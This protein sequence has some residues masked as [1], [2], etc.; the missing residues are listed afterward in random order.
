MPNFIAY[1]A[2]FIANNYSNYAQLTVV[3]PSQR[4]IK[5]IQQELFRVHKHPVFSPNFITIDAFAKN[6]VDEEL[7]DSVDLLFRFY[8]VYIKQGNDADFET[9]LNWAPM[10]IADCNEID[11]YLVDALQ[12]FKNLRDVKELENWSFD[13]GR[14]LSESQRKFLEFWDQLKDYYSAINVDLSKDGLAYSGSVFRKA[15]ENLDERLDMVYGEQ[16]FL[17]AGFNALSEAELQLMERLVKR[18]RA[19]ILAEADSF[20][21]HNLNHEAGLFIR[22]TKARIPDLK[23]YLSNSLEQDVKQIQ[24]V[25]CAQAGSML[26]VTQDLLSQMSQT[27]IND[28]VLLLADESLIVPA[29]KHLPKTV[30]K[31]NITLG[32][33]LKLTAIRPWLEL[34]FEFQNNFSYFN[35]EALYHKTLMAFFR[36]PF[37][38]RLLSPD[39]KQIVLREEQNI[40]RFNKIFTKLTLEPFSE[41]VQALLKLVFLPWGNDFAKALE[42]ILTINKRVFDAL[43]VDNDL[44]ERSALFHFQESMKGLQVVFEKEYVP[45][46]TLRSFEKFFNMRWMRESVA[47][48]G[49]P[50][51]GL[52]VMGLLETRLLC[53]KNLIVVGLNEGVMPPKNV[54]NSLIPMDLRRFFNLPLPAEK[55]ALFAHHFYRLLSGAERLHILYSTNQGDDISAAE[56]S[57]YIKQIELELAAKNPNVQIT[58]STYNIPVKMGVEPQRFE[59]TKSV[60]DRIFEQFESGLSPSAMNKFLSCPLDYYYR[61]VL[62]YSD[63]DEVEENVESSTFG[64]VVHEVLEILYKPFVGNK[65]VVSPADITS[66]LGLYSEEV[67]RCFK[68]KFE[69]NVD[70]FERGAMYFAT[71][72]AKKQIR[73]FLNFERQLLLEHPDKELKIVALEQ[74]LSHHIVI[75]FQGVERKIALYGVIDRIDQFGDELRIVDYKTGACKPENVTV[76]GAVSER[77]LEALENW[78]SF[79]FKKEPDFGNLGA[80][81]A[82]QLL[83]YLVLYKANH[84]RFPDNV[85][86]YSL[87][88]VSSGLQTLGFGQKRGKH[89]LV[90]NLTIDKRLVQFTEGYIKFV[91]QSILEINEFFHDEQ[92]KY[93]KFCN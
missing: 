42:S 66:M 80:S 39:D 20:Y 40:I 1:I 38:E 27:E 8:Q 86:I 74:K 79:D 43:D 78:D 64:S 2:Q 75:D 68:A 77:I 21:L 60:Q 31:A 54:V 73:R 30:G 92:S 59:N 83:F 4:A 57:R 44:V 19:H 13:Q 55:D 3:L 50:T 65:K 22:T 18:G 35:T 47:Y 67:D 28:T 90:H 16:D 17:F 32:L 91:A 88:N 15:I 69:S 85:G 10:L 41:D 76:N 48:Y 12:L 81:H 63:E 36:H 93:C 34:L 5:Y 71:V 23:I 53:F 33:P 49:N 25:E 82:M 51:H 7:V 58:K 89:A 87:R 9:F 62:K 29:I 24:L 72:A 11:R 52:Q 45:P 6:L 46:M 14:E 56:P 61:Y 26:K 84:E 70:L 37:M